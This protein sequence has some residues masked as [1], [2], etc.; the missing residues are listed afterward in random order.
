MPRQGPIQGK[1][2]LKNGWAP[3]T[4]STQTE[5][6][7]FQNHKTTNKDSI[8][9]KQ[10]K[11]K[12]NNKCTYQSQLADGSQSPYFIKTPILPVTPFLTIFQSPF[13]IISKLHGHCSFYCLVSLSEWV[14][15][16]HLMCHLMILWIYK[17]QTLVPQHQKDLAVFYAIKYQ[18]D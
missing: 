17:C 7:N 4:G 13:H 3:K 5:T 11:L 15:A 1:L 8:G 10:L 14:I 6:S 12:K 18:V 2:L 16:P 9:S